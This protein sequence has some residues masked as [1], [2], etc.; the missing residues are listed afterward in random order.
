MRARAAARSRGTSMQRSARA[1]MKREKASSTAGAMRIAVTSNASRASCE[2]KPR[3]VRPML[4]SWRN[5]EISPTRI[6]PAALR[7]SRQWGA[8]YSREEKR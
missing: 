3:L 5:C 6:F 2:K 8:T 1:L 7:L 4:W